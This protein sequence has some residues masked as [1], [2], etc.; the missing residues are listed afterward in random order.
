MSDSEAGE[1]GEGAAG[2]GA[3]PP[4]KKSKIKLPDF[5]N[6]DKKQ[7]I[8][9]GA[10]AAVVLGILA[11]VI[12]GGGDAED[13]GEPPPT[14]VEDEPEEDD[15]LFGDLDAAPPPELSVGPNDPTEVGPNDWALKVA[16]G[17][18]T[19]RD[20]AVFEAIDDAFTVE[21]WVKGDML[22]ADGSVFLK[23]GEDAEVFRLGL[24]KT[25]DGMKAE[26]A[27]A[28]EPDRILSAVAPEGGWIHLAGVYAGDAKK[29][30]L[31]FVNG[32]R[33]ATETSRALI[34]P[35]CSAMIIEVDAIEGEALVDDI[36]VSNSARHL[37]HF[38]PNRKQRL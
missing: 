25:A 19:I 30:L 33:M 27:S 34:T 38:R 16:P 3:T 31:L 22:P 13:T 11:V 9:V 15:E 26:F 5:K 18:V 14:V 20:G 4:K 21:F 8:I 37:R 28:I 29:V 12:L 10:V 35:A 36:H 17:R 24:R 32:S 1:E 23:G 6:M 2:D 7:K